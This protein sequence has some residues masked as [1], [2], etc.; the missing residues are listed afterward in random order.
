MHACLISKP[1]LVVVVVEYNARI[2]R[3]KNKKK[4]KKKQK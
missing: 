2:I 4:Q 1:L 3:V